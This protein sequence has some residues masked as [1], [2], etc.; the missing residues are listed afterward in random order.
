MYLYLTIIYQSD[1]Q[2][3]RTHF[4]CALLFVSFCYISNNPLICSSEVAGRDE[5]GT[6]NVQGC[7]LQPPPALVYTRYYVIAW[8]TMYRY[9]GLVLTITCW[10]VR[11]R[12]LFALTML[13][14]WYWTCFSGCGTHLP[15]SVCG[16]YHRRYLMA[17]NPTV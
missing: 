5:T 2:L 1:S 9:S 14:G 16:V 3:L 6:W 11:V 17:W 13:T 8:I 15:D 7:P 4:S 10:R 12:G